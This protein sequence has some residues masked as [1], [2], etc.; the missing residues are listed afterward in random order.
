MRVPMEANKI[1][2][3]WGQG[4]NPDELNTKEKEVQE[5][6]LPCGPRYSVSLEIYSRNLLIEVT[7]YST[8]YW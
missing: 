6:L 1:L 4:D 2:K 3:D 5:Q 7:L 8:E